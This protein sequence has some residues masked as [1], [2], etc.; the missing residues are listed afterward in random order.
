M[1]ELTGALRETLHEKENIISELEQL[2]RAVNVDYQSEITRLTGAYQ[3]CGELPPE[4]AELLD[5]RFAVAVKAAN[6][7]ETLFAARKE[8]IAKLSSE[9]DSLLAADELAT[10]KEVE[11]LEKNILEIDPQSDLLAR[12]APL[13]SRLQ[14]EEAAVRAAGEAVL[15]LAAEL[16]EL[17][18]AG[19]ITPLHDRKAE[20]EAEFAQLA[21]IPR[22]AAL[23]Y[24]EAHHKAS[25][26]LAQHYETLDLA[27][28]ENYT[29]KL[30]LC[31][32]LEKMLEYSDEELSGGSKK[33]NELREQWKKLGSVPKEKSEEINPRYLDLTR[34]VQHK[35]DE[36]FA[37]KRQ[38]QKIASAEKETL[39]AE[40]EALADSSDWKNTA[41]KMRDLQARWKIL[42]RAGAKENE[43]YQRFRA[44]LDKFFNARKAVFDEREKR[45][46]ACAEV[47][48]A[49]IAEAENLTDPRRARQLRE[50]FRNAGFA[51][52]ND[53]SLYEKFNAAMDKFF[54]ARKAE[55][56]SKEEHIKELIAEI[57]TLTA[58]PAESLPRIR[59]IREELR[60]NPLYN[61]RHRA[62]AALRAF[63]EALNEVWRNEQRKKEENSDSMA[64]KLADAY[65]AWKDGSAVAVPD[66]ADFA[67]FN[68]LQSAAKLLAQAV[69]GDDKAAMKL[70]RQ[71][72]TARG[73]RLR[74]CEAMEALGGKAPEK[75][76]VADLAAELQSAMLGDFGKNGTSASVRCA[77]PQ[78]L[79]AQFAA[80][81]IVPPE[82]LS[83]LQKRFARAKAVLKLG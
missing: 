5:K 15:K 75:D 6:E 9:T 18:A 71:I 31:A 72:E 66:A 32:A 4:F 48:N 23:R 51:G 69:A 68:K 19:E 65:Q 70:E 26:T 41:V 67:G 60:Q 8:R 62:E 35:I 73:E 58:A 10:L 3:A 82:E 63:D 25:V 55:N 76:A 40:A 39:C 27:R 22:Q 61:I 77:D 2:S 13:K 29:R 16:E 14:S 57:G 36:F 34:K 44:A 78:E 30:D 33:L 24:N 46:T 38:M 37:R 49:L 83:G 43:L 17:C 50:E 12:I 81:G 42:P 56:A 7:G 1:S 64:A 21:N 45:F 59:E 74:I 54:N 79:C 28:W 20:I 80:C 47:K 53:Q 11:I 52:K